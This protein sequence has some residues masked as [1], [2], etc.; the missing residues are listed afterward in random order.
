MEAYRTTRRGVGLGYFRWRSRYHGEAVPG[1]RLGATG[2]LHDAHGDALDATF[3]TATAL[4]RKI[5]A[6]SVDPVS[7]GVLNAAFAFVYVLDRPTF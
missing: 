3:N 4:L 6:S 1:R 5:V 2:G 7:I